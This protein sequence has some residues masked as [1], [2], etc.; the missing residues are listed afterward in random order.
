MTMQ[1]RL[2]LLALDRARQ[3]EPNLNHHD[4]VTV[5]AIRAPFKAG[6]RWMATAYCCE[7]SMTFE[8]GALAA[9]ARSVH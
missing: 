6:G 1:E 8:C 7:G 5:V 4:C 3:I 9:S 2:E